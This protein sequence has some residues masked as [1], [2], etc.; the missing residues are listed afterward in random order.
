MIFPVLSKSR[1][2]I[3]VVAVSFFP[4][5]A[6]IQLPLSGFGRVIKIL[7]L[8]LLLSIFF[9]RS[10]HFVGTQPKI[11]IRPRNGINM[12]SLKV[13]TSSTRVRK[14][15]H[16][17]SFFSVCLHSLHSF[18]YA[19]KRKKFDSMGTTC[20]PVMYSENERRAWVILFSLQLELMSCLLIRQASVSKSFASF[21][22]FADIIRLHPIRPGQRTPRAKCVNVPKALSCNS[23]IVTSVFNFFSSHFIPFWR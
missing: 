19:A 20:V 10:L 4:S 2:T 15:F 1:R 8:N 14:K 5:S 6:R 23:L 13:H 7:K 22:P 18:D 17:N 12:I 3:F 9:F 16:F 21:N 11:Q